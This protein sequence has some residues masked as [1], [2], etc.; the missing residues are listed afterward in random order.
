VHVVPMKPVLRAPGYTLLKLIYNGPLS[1]FASKF[2]LRCYN[3][4]PPG[5]LEQCVGS[6]GKPCVLGK[7]GFGE[8]GRCRLIVSNPV[9]RAPAVSALTLEHHKLVSTFALHFYL[10]RCTEVIKVGRC[11][12][13]VSKPELT[14][15]IVSALVNMM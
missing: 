7:G 4:V 8:V 1:N 5:E 2:N 15:T 6:D 14:A 10:S 13:T 12:R 9:L 3:E 11:R